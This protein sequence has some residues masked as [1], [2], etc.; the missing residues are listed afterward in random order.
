MKAI[1]RLLY[2]LIA[3]SEGGLNRARILLALRERPINSHQLAERLGLNYKTVRH[4]LDVLERNELIMTSGDRYG[5]VFFIS[6]LL[7]REWAELEG[8]LAGFGQTEIREA[9]RKGG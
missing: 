8:I 3:G 1:G 7:E 6:P 5:K 9:L 2:W 4:H